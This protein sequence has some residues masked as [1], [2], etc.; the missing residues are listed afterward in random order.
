MDSSTCGVELWKNSYFVA[1]CCLII[2]LI[3]FY[4]FKIGYTYT[5]NSDGEIVAKYNWVYPL[6]ISLV[7]WILWHFWFFPSPE[8]KMIGGT[9]DEPAPSLYYLADQVSKRSGLV[10]IPYS[11]GVDPQRINTAVIY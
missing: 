7:I 6:A 3:F 11:H 1:F 2:L 10:D 8:K 5:K 4:V 9:S